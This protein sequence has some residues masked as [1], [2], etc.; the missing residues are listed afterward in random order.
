MGFDGYVACLEARQRRELD[1]LNALDI[2]KLTLTDPF[3]SWD[4]A[5][6]ALYERL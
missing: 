6:A 3:R 5:L 2:R 1:M 4:A